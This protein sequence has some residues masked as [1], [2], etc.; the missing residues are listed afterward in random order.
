MPLWS[1]CLPSCRGGFGG[2]AGATLGHRGLPD[3]A[4]RYLLAATLAASGLKLILSH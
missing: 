2:L 4:L 3:H 1:G